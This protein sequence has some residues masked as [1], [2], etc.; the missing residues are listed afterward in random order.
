MTRFPMLLATTLLAGS[1]VFP[2]MAQTTPSPTPPASAPAPAAPA[3]PAPVS[4][5]MPAA[6]SKPDQ[7]SVAEARQRSMSANNDALFEAHVAALHAGL[8]LSPDQE[9]LWPAVDQ[10][11]R[12]VKAMREKLGV[13]HR[14]MHE[15]SEQ[16]PMAALKTVGENLITRG[17]ALTALADAASPFYASLSDEQ[18]ERLPT[19]LRDLTPREGPVSRMV[20]EL[21]RAAG[22]GIESGDGM[23]AGQGMD[24][25]RGMEPDRD[26]PADA[27]PRG[28]F[29]RRGET[30]YD[31]RD[32]HRDREGMERGWHG[33]DRFE[34]EGRDGPM[35]E[36]R[37][38]HRDHGSDDTMDGED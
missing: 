33:E 8:T 27:G 24:T 6:S 30:F 28:R 25:D 23:R 3:S 4:T 38:N 19:L 2:A 5:P 32:W 35:R 11:I 12:G 13:D 34:T 37:W 16:D 14:R 17:Q 15:T 20:Q 22:S 1:V 36:H 21:D 18:K 10:A 31:H 26:G 9:R 29:D 7:V